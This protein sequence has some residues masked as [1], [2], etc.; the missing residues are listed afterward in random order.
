MDQERL[1][2]V[3]EDEEEDRR[4]AVDQESNCVA[5]GDLRFEAERGEPR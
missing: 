3:E 5:P 2:C 1:R 4:G